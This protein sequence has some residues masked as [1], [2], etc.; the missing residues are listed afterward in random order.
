MFFAFF[1]SFTPEKEVTAEI[2]QS[3]IM[4]C[5]Q[6]IPTH[7][8][9]TTAPSRTSFPALF[10]MLLRSCIQHCC[11]RCCFRH[12]C[13]KRTAQSTDSFLSC[14][15]QLIRMS[16]LQDAGQQWIIPRDSFQATNE[17]F[18][19][20]VCCKVVFDCS[21]PNTVQICARAFG[22][23]PLNLPFRL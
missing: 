9:G 20:E 8:N 19:K 23:F 14:V 2:P 16:V 12:V 11:Q 15:L 10:A 17:G 18:G 21:A 6:K 1:R 3:T 13:K 22:G 5:I 4:Q 7:S